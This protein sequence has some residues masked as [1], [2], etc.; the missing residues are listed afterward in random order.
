MGAAQSSQLA[1]LQHNCLVQLGGPVALQYNAEFGNDLLSPAA[2][3]LASVPP[4]EVYEALRPVTQRI[5]KSTGSGCRGVPQ[6]PLSKWP[7]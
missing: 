3:P 2:V 7:A 6:L 1:A 5:R 4:E